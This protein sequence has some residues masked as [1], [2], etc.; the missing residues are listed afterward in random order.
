MN[1]VQQFEMLGRKQLAIQEGIDL[2]RQIQID[3]SRARAAA[4]AWGVAAVMS[5]VTLIPL[6]II[7][8]A[9]ELKAA[10]TAYQVLVRQLYGKFGKS[11]TRL[12]GQAKTALSLLKQAITEELK[13][14][15]MTEFV[16]GVNILIGLAEDSM[17]A[18]QAIQL[19]DSGSRE[20]S[21]RANDLE[22]KIVI[23]NQQLMQLG[24]KRADILG[25]MQVYGRT[26]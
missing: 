13:R 7:V 6:N 21:I 15:A 24:I 10:N 12:D 3:L 5:N 17:A 22:R 23:A 1:L 9:F 18:W 25:R 11:G 19:V 20:I 14:K 2:L 26:A 16:P 4:D 8:N